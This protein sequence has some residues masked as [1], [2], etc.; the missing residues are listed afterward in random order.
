M[1]KVKKTN[2]QRVLKLIEE[3]GDNVLCVGDENTVLKC[4]KCNINLKYSRKSNIVKHLKSVKH[5]KNVGSSSSSGNPENAQDLGPASN[6]Q[7]QECFNLQLCHAMV[8]ANI[9]F[10]KLENEAFNN[11]LEQYTGK[12]IPHESTLRRIMLIATT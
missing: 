3:F 9:P 12:V 11:F 2:G 1:P 5:T 7:S 10:W 6:S 4:V 8:S